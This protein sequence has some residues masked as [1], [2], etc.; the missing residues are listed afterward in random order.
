MS[1]KQYGIYL[2]LIYSSPLTLIF[3]TGYP[4]SFRSLIIYLW[5][6]GVFGPLLILVR[7]SEIDQPRT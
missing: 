4:V 1:L 6:R 3:Y 7:G 2:G 5:L